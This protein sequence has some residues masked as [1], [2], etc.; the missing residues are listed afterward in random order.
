MK[1]E[2]DR[3][4]DT[5]LRGSRS[6]VSRLASHASLTGAHP[7]ADELSAYA[8]NALPQAARSRYA[9]HIADCKECRSVVTTIALASGGEK[10][11]AAQPER[12]EGSVE[13]R[14]G[15]FASL[16]ALKALRYALPALAFALVALI[17]LI[18]I[19]RRPADERQIAEKR[20]EERRESV[21]VENNSDASDATPSA[22]STQNLRQGY[23]E[24]T[25]GGATDASAA[26]APA[27]PQ[28]GRAA[29]SIDG[30]RNDAGDRE[31]P[32]LRMEPGA[33]L[34][35]SE[36]VTPPP[37]PSPQAREAQSETARR[38]ESRAAY[39]VAREEDKAVAR[40]SSEETKQLGV[41]NR[42]RT[43]ADA[44]APA[45]ASRSAG[46]AAASERDGSASKDER[47]SRVASEAAKPSAETRSVAGREFRREG[48]AW[49]DVNYR[50]SMSLN[51][52]RR[53]SERFISLSADM[54]E[55]ER[56]ANQLGGTVIVVLRGRAYRIR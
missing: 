30:L 18:V 50:A 8:E 35:Q 23:A 45:S 9:S 40:R 55:L 38:D 29:D 1:E 28:K 3:E 10:L 25:G 47:R 56:V 44:T 32:K 20:P 24:T 51:E 2:F 46:A 17:A 15:W 43:Q 22:P 7:D 19:Q 34:P 42:E 52:V 36:N 39:E 37:P 27:S 5:L 54:P 26:N 48:G 21:S 14:R 49:I 31:G 6:A 33:P 16:F 53:G 11:R 12:A 4:L 13:K 41:L